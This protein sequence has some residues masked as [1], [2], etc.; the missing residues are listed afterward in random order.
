MFVLVATALAGNLIGWPCQRLNWGWRNVWSTCSINSY[1]P[2]SANEPPA[3]VPTGFRQTFDQ[4]VPSITLTAGGW[5]RPTAATAAVPQLLCT[6]AAATGTGATANLRNRCRRAIDAYGALVK[7]CQLPPQ[8]AGNRGAAPNTAVAPDFAP[9][10]GHQPHVS[11]V[12]GLTVNAQFCTM[13]AG[14]RVPGDLATP[15]NTC[16]GLLGWFTVVFNACGF[17]NSPGLAP[18]AQATANAPAYTAAHFPVGSVAQ[19]TVLGSAV[20][21]PVN[22]AGYFCTNPSTNGPSGTTGP[23][24]WNLAGS[25]FRTSRCRKALDQFGRTAQRCHQSTAIIGGPAQAGGYSDPL[26]FLAVG[27][28]GA[29]PTG[30]NVW[31][32][33]CN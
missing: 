15:S 8:T 11:N 31:A 4:N 26:R 1:A 16:P 20:V 18:A 24:A 6:S 30:I 17:T 19:N 14:V 5:F 22:G 21:G 2:H 29:A 13:P 9:A 32:P 28:A 23:T 33:A 25:A 10:A 7:S 3:Q 27:S 12:A